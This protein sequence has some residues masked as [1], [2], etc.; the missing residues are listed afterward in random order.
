MKKAHLPLRKV[1]HVEFRSLTRVFD[2]GEVLLSEN[3]YLEL[4]CGHKVR[5]AP[6]LAG[7]RRIRCDRC[8]GRRR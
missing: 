1:T 6:S 7:R 2:G 3:Y 5:S 4:D 8:E